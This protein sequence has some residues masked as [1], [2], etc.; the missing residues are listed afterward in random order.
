MN[1]RLPM[2]AALVFFALLITVGFSQCSGPTTSTAP[3]AAAPPVAM[4]AVP[5]RPSDA[6]STEATVKT[7]AARLADLNALKEDQATQNAQMA[8]LQKELDAARESDAARQGTELGALRESLA[9]LKQQNGALTE[10]LLQ[11]ESRAAS[12][13][14]AVGADFGIGEGAVPGNLTTGVPG[15]P[16]AMV[17]P[18]TPSYAWV[19]PLDQVPADPNAPATTNAPASFAQ[20]GEITLAQVADSGEALV[21]NVSAAGTELVNGGVT[22]RFTLPVNSTLL[23]NTAMTAFIG[24]VPVNGTVTDPYRFKILASAE[25]LATNGFHLPPDIKSM[26]FSG[27]ASGDWSLSCV[28]GQIDSLTFTYEDGSVQTYGGD[29]ATR[30]GQG[31]QT[32]RRVLGYIS[33]PYGVPCIAGTKITNAPKILTAQLAASAFEA[34]ARGYAEAQTTSVVT[35]TGGVVRTIDDAAKFGVFNGVAGGAADAQSWLQSRLGQIF[36]A[37]YVPGGATVAIHIETQINLDH[38]PAGRRL[39]YADSQINTQALD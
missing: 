38:D 29:V 22:P 28:R 35:G 18:T 7:L 9:Q 16:L 15:A 19:R 25:G 33:D 2:V 26:V 4:P 21:S 17:A 1:N 23:N 14:E 31:E 27:S 10:R 34:T 20:T 3:I 5:A 12:P 13:S 6:D 30:T 36:D 24:R 11:V 32:Q 39:S 8:A 37:V